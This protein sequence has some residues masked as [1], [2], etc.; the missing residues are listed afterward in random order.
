MDVAEG[1]SAPEAITAAPAEEPSA[2]PALPLIDA[3]APSASPELPPI[4]APA[5]SPTASPELAPVTPPDAPEDE[6]PQ[7]QSTLFR[8]VVV[9]PFWAGLLGGGAGIWTACVVQALVSAR[10]LDRPRPAIA[11]FLPFVVALGAALWRGFRAPL[12][13]YSA[14]AGRVFGA[15]FFGSAS[16]G[17]VVL[18]VGSIFDGMRVRDQPAYLTLAL[19]GALLAG[20]A[21]ARIHGIGTGRPR[22][23]KIAAGV[24]AV[25]LV[26]AW[27]ASPSLRCRLG[28]GEGCR[29]AADFQGDQG[30]FVA[31][32]ALGARGCEHED[33]ASCR[34]AGQAFQSP[35]PARDLRRAE[36]Y[37]R[38]GCALGDPES[39]D[40]VHAMELEQRCDHYGAFACVELAR[41]H[42]RGEGM[43]RNAALAQRYYRKACLLGADDACREGGGR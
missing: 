36:G 20:L 4:D 1:A 37:Y 14:L 41:G 30:D 25:I 29:A 17:I 34:L 3:S 19:V 32:G 10:L 11:F 40:G 26:C 35:G 9:G 7:F 18:I 42:E 39:C 13:S 24:A 31:A 21:L 15:L 2:S 12:Q 33:A 22:R 16:A 38:E 27:P 23:I 28:F 43:P 5:P 8:R 6:A